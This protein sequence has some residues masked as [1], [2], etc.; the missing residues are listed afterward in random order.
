MLFMKKIL[1]GF[2]CFFA[3]IFSMQA[4]TLYG[5]TPNGG[6]D[7]GGTINKFIPATNNL[8]VAK[9]F[10]SI[11]STNGNNPCA[12]LV[13]ASDGKLYGM[14]AYGG[15][16]NAGVIFSF[17]RISSTYT[18]LKDFDNTNGANPYGSLIQASDG[19]LYGMTTNGGSSN[20]GVIFSFDP[21]SSIYTKLKDF[22]GTNGGHP[23]GSLMQAK[24]GKL[25][26]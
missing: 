1:L 20:A 17:D 4:Q 12:S 8:I 15:S 5:T 13:K 18:N 24:D 11:T 26:A 19:K 7:G 21:S 16:S 22:D 10:E 25:L 23:Y 2:A 14:T 3:Y 9:S 6:N